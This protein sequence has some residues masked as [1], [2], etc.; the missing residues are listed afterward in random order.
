MSR[1]SE[2]ERWA[3]RVALAAVLGA[4]ACSDPA[5]QVFN[6]VTQDFEES[7]DG[8]PCEW[9]QLSGTPGQV[10]WVE[11]FHSGDHG[12]ELTGDGV[13]ARGPGG[14]PMMVQV[15]SGSLQ[16]QLVAVCD[17]GATLRLSVG[18]VQT[19]GFDGG[20][21]SVVDTLVADFQPE[22]EWGDPQVRTLIA[23]GVFT[24]GG[25][26]GGFVSGTFRITGMTIEKRGAGSCVVSRVLVDDVI[27]VS[28]F[29]C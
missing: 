4:L 12:L 15:I 14:S 22:G 2:L 16:G 18:L 26:G 1:A 24:D 8:V 19:T 6:L 27:A 10:R 9:E 21:P 5:P 29:D 3:A 23:T 7:C 20:M 17:P 28:D 13:A 11:T 25:L